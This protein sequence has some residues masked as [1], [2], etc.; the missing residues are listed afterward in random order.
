MH[1]EFRDT[2]VRE[3][4]RQICGAY[5]LTLDDEKM[6]LDGVVT[7]RFDANSAEDALAMALAESPFFGW[8]QSGW[9]PGQVLLIIHDRRG[10]D[11]RISYEHEGDSLWSLFRAIPEFFPLGVCVGPKQLKDVER[12]AMKDAPLRE[13]LDVACAKGG[14]RWKEERGVVLIAEDGSSPAPWPVPESETMY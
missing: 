3:V 4:V 13:I 12:F 11:D 1:F 14:L 2:P 10:L 8:I 6:P 7:A 9:L 5:K